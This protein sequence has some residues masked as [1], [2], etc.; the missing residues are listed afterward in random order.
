MSIISK[1]YPVPAELG[2][3]APNAANHLKEVGLKGISD[4][5]TAIKKSFE[6][7]LA[8]N[9]K[10]VPVGQMTNTLIGS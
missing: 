9:S 1:Q 3:V 6:L 7:D 10:S 8:N 4:T 5:G 2:N